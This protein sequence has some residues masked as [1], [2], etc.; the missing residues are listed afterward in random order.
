M[1]RLRLIS[2][3]FRACRRRDA[4]AASAATAA[5]LASYGWTP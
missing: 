2:Y 5:L 3:W 1:Y 4:H